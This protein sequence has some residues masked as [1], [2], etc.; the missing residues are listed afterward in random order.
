MRSGLQRII[1]IDTHIKGRRSEFR[2]GQHA[3]LSGTNGAGKTTLLRLIPFFYGANPSSLSAESN[4]HRSFV[5]WYLPRPTSLIIY[6]YR[7]PLRM[8]C[9]VVYRHSSGDKPVYRFLTAPFGLE[10]FTREGTEGLVYL[11]GDSL[12]PHWVS[13][14]LDH[15]RQFERVVDY[16]AIIQNDRALIQRAGG[17]KDLFGYAM[18]YSLGAKVGAMKHVEKVALSVLERSGDM[19]NIR[20]MIADIMRDEG[21]TLPPLKLHKDIPATMAN[22]KVLREFDK[23]LPA[24]QQTI[25]HAYE[26]VGIQGELN[27]LHAELTVIRHDL[28]RTIADTQKLISHIEENMEKH[29]LAWQEDRAS[30]E[31]AISNAK[32]ALQATKGRLNTLHAAEAQWDEEDIIEKANAVDQWVAFEAAVEQAR[33]RLEGLTKVVKDLDAH[34]SNRL[35]SV[36]ESFQ[37]TTATYDARIYELQ[38]SGA[39]LRANYDN[40]KDI[41][42]RNFQEEREQV[43][44][45]NQIIYDE[46]REQLSEAQALVKHGRETDD[47]ILQRH[48]AVQA[49][50]A[51]RDI[52]RQTQDGCDTCDEAYRQVLERFNDADRRHQE[53]IVRKDDFHEK[54]EKLY[55]W[56]S[57]D[58]NTF[59]AKLRDEDPNWHDGLGRIVNL[60]LLART[61]LDPTKIDD[62]QMLFGWQLNLAV[63]NKPDRAASLEEI[64]RDIEE[65][66]QLHER[67][68]EY[69]AHTEKQRY[70][71]ESERH[72]CKSQLDRV[73]IELTTAK[74]H[75]EAARAALRLVENEISDAMVRRKQEA[76][77]RASELEKSCSQL[78]QRRDEA[79]ATVSAR[80]AEYMRELSDNF[81][82]EDSRLSQQIDGIRQAVTDSKQELEANKKVI[83]QDYLKACAGKGVDEPTLNEAEKN[84]SDAQKRVENINSWRP[85]VSEY[86]RWYEYEW[87]ENANL[88]QLRQEQEGLLTAAEH[89]L[90]NCERQYLDGLR[91]LQNSRTEQQRVSREQNDTL[92]FVEDSLARLRVPTK[93]EHCDQPRSPKLVFTDVDGVLESQRTLRQAI[94]E[95]VDKAERLIGQYPQSQIYAGWSALRG[96]ANQ[97]HARDNN[98]EFKLALATCLEHLVNDHLPQARST[99]IGFVRATG[100]QLSLFY[101]NMRN[102]SGQIGNHSR[103]INSAINSGMQFDALKNINV[104]LSS[105]IESLDYW[106]ALQEFYAAWQIWQ[107][108]GDD[109]LPP[110]E[111]DRSLQNVT[112]AIHNARLLTAIDNVFDLIIEV[113]ENGHCVVAHNQREL[114]SIS[115]TGLSSL[116][117][118]SLFAGITRMLCA[119]QDVAMHWPVDELGTLAPENIA[120]LFD[121]MTQSNIVMVGGFPT[122]DPTFLRHFHEHHHLDKERGIVDVVVPE[123]ELSRALSRRPTKP[124]GGTH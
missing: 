27:S 10:Y 104:R 23:Q 82:I 115:S 70:H 43:R 51:K 72:S 119:D 26:Y 123:D 28:N 122:T 99:L 14:G 12:A 78:K 86:R 74:R 61:D 98:D 1:L 100:G 76:K 117:L 94:N 75:E 38:Q 29:N 96:E 87:A 16:R 17:A 89:V 67:A 91:S 34:R 45:S 124:T 102:V 9:V 3:N 50:E 65:A 18:K 66:E 114:E 79:V 110:T 68:V 36:L 71:V 46:V 113:E 52:V 13:L 47:E 103:R 48:D 60:D 90:K 21:V 62:S 54:L 121:M 22:I 111:L 83:Q 85:R 4:N 64:Q 116:T 80:E 53:A 37:K 20:Q 63:I 49:W 58:T 73:R 101:S 19:D 77:T 30:M 41:Q 15:S 56:Y 57:P 109:V 35:N 6:E 81:A 39:R 11:E 5:D 55:Q 108:S 25:R 112:E 93:I 120:K 33:L 95:G 106:S 7:S 118:Y 97:K 42:R 107:D 69:V 44:Q 88:T 84:L 8:H 105:R 2:V 32:I 59:L 92:S 40:K 31:S 24:I